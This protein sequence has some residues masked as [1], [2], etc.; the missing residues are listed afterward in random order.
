VRARG[1]GPAS[2]GIPASEPRRTLAS[3]RAPRPPGFAMG[4]PAPRPRGSPSG[5]SYGTARGPRPGVLP[6]AGGLCRGAHR[7][8]R[9][10]PG[11]RTGR[12]RGSSARCGHQVRSR[13]LPHRGTVQYVH[14]QF[15]RPTESHQAAR[16][17]GRNWPRPAPAGPHRNGWT[18][19]RRGSRFLY[20]LL[21]PT[22]DPT[23]QIR[24]APRPAALQET[25]GSRLAAERMGV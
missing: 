2:L 3:N 9:D 25:R 10:G 11:E 21:L 18:A 19:P 5:R 16:G 14:Q 23:K 22:S 15:I 1:R 7:G 8:P 13:N 4:A 24:E 17:R 20:Y 6:W 12:A